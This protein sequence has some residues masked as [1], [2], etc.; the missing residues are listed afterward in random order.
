MGRTVAKEA[1][2]VAKSEVH[3]SD[4]M[5]WVHVGKAGFWFPGN[6]GVCCQVGYLNVSS[7]WH[8]RPSVC[9]QV[10]R[11]ALTAK[12]SVLVVEWAP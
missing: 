10:Y 2:S 12:D 3:L 6:V 9:R 8:G 4:V 11:A 1:V 5:C 7:R